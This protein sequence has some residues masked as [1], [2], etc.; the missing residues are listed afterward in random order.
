LGDSA[1]DGKLIGT[2]IAFGVLRDPELED[3]GES[4]G[5]SVSA[6][7]VICGPS[8]LIKLMTAGENPIDD[9]RSPISLTLLVPAASAESSDGVSLLRGVSALTRSLCVTLGV[10]SSASKQLSKALASPEIMLEYG[11]DGHLREITMRATRFRNHFD[12]LAIAWIQRSARL[13]VTENTA[14]SQYGFL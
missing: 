10:A 9:C 12:D 6:L 13:I 1:G 2:A 3:L 5:R 11:C 14:I 8:Y 7:N 4:E